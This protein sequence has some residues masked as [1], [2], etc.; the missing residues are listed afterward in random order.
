MSHY[1]LIISIE[2]HCNDQQQTRMA[3]IFVD[4]LRDFLGQSML[5]TENLVEGKDSSRRRL[6]SPLELQ[7]KI[8]LKGSYREHVSHKIVM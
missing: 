2:N 4:E 7:G 8:L 3:K 5:A 6:P 1:P